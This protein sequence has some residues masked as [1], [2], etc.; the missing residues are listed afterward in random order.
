MSKGIYIVA[1]NKVAENAIALL[2]SIRYYD[3]D[4]D[5]YLI[6]FD[7]NYHDLATNL[8]ASHNVQLFPD[9]E[10]LKEFT[11]VV[12]KT[13]DRNFL[14]LPNKMRKLVVWFGPLEEF[15]YIDTDIIVF[16]KI[17]NVLDYLSEFD[18]LCSDYHHLGRGLQDIFSP[19]IQ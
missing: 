8:K 1:N 5:I 17:A 16:E 15:L 6:P 9:L 18:F 2:N 3:P 13:F 11:E 4:V 14:A 19:Q 7:D 10:F 12:A